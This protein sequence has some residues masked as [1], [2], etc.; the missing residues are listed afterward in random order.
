MKLKELIEKLDKSKDNESNVNLNS[1]AE[2]EFDI[3]N[4]SWEACV[5]QEGRLK[6]YWIKNWYCTDSIVGWRAYFLDDEFV[7]TSMQV[8]RKHTEDFD[9]VSEL[10][11]WSVKD[12][13]LSLTIDEQNLNGFSFLDLEEELTEDSYLIEFADELLPSHNAKA[14]L[15]GKPVQILERIH[16]KGNKYS[17]ENNRVKILNEGEKQIVEVQDLKF[18]YYLAGEENT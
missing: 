12:F 17:F 9:W 13:L 2:N 1:L 7:G 14:K 8:G 6:A 11:L 10:A 5:E 18:G 4:L 15:N 16:D 3:F